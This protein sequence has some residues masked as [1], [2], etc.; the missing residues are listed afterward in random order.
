[1]PSPTTPHN[2][3]LPAT[4]SGSIES[5]SSTDV[6]DSPVVSSLNSGPDKSLG[7]EVIEKSRVF[8]QF[9][10]VPIEDQVRVSS[11]GAPKALVVT[12]SP[13]LSSVPPRPALE[14]TQSRRISKRHRNEDAPWSGIVSS[15]SS[16]S[17]GCNLF[18]LWNFTLVR[19]FRWWRKNGERRFLLSSW[20]FLPMRIWFM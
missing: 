18:L 6:P 7:S 14:L 9:S 8:N 4:F 12:S 19:N 16:H 10:S 3:G 20:V 2:S 1:M 11:D 17:V 13:V 15:S 5:V